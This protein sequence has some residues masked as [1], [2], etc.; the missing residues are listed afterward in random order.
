[1]SQTPS[2]FKRVM[3]PLMINEV[4][5]G[6]SAWY[7]ELEPRVYER[8]PEE[9]F[10][11]VCEVV[12]RH[13]RWTPETDNPKQM[14]LDVEV[15]TK[16]VRFIDDMIIWVQPTEGGKAE[17]SVRSSSRVG[18]ADLGQNARTIEELFERLDRRIR[19]RG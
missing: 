7:P 4:E 5:T 1:M 3:R 11:A 19:S 9:V 15:R 8:D 16:L 10:D 6:K 12:D 2:L 17:V 18:R 13:P 14:R